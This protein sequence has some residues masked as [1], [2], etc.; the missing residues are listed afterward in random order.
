MDNYDDETRDSPPHTS[1]S[2]SEVS[3]GEWARLAADGWP[4]RPGWHGQAWRL[5]RK[6]RALQVDTKNMEAAKGPVIAPRLL[7]VLRYLHDTARRKVGELEAKLRNP[8]DLYAL[9]TAEGYASR[10]EG[11]E[12]VRKTEDKYDYLEFLFHQLF[13]EEPYIRRNY[14][15]E[16]ARERVLD[17]ITDPEVRE[18]VAVLTSNTGVALKAAHA[19]AKLR[20]RARRTAHNNWNPDGARGGAL[21][22]QYNSDGWPSHSTGR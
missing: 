17:T 21:I 4:N 20:L 22:E 6:Y 7:L 14:M 2:E 8:P 12:Y 9:A 16:F 10:N 19:V 15:D 11:Y 3:D 18:I 1:D 5:M 13:K